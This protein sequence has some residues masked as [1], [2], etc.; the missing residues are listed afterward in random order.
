MVTV[1]G[2]SVVS[3]GVAC[4]LSVSSFV[5]VGRRVGAETVGAKG[6]ALN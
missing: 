2:T 1:D 3:D 6:A 4:G 5:P